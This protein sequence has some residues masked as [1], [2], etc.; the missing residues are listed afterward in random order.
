[1]QMAKH[2]R[3]TLLTCELPES[4]SVLYLCH[5]SDGTAWGNEVGKKENKF[6]VP[7]F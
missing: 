5:L 3:L 6:G 2:G 7:W 4:G 1:M